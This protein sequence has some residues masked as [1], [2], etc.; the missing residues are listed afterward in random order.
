[1]RWAC[2]KIDMIKKPTHQQ[3]SGCLSDKDIQLIRKTY[4]KL[5]ELYYEN[6][7]NESIICNLIKMGHLIT[8]VISV[9]R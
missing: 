4:L 6:P 8:Q 9:K 3:V 5:T 2:Y 7:K 1:M